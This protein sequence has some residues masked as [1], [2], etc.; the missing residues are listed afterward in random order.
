MHGSNTCVAS[1]RCALPLLV[2]RPQSLTTS[3]STTHLAAQSTPSCGVTTLA[4]THTTVL[5]VKK[6]KFVATAG[7]ITSVEDAVQLLQRCADPCA[8][9]NCYAYQLASGTIA[10]AS[11][12]GEPSGTAGRPIL[13]A[14]QAEG[15]DGVA[16]VVVR[17]VVRLTA[18]YTRPLHNLLLGTMVASNW[19]Q[20]ASPV[21]MG[22]RPAIACG[23]R[24]V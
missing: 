16:V 18:T 12:D 13:S 8:S 23:L 4:D 15:L 7:P 9:H 19:V 14:I 11:D 1:L 5:E 10:K 20:V 3:R 6:S 2:L 17:Y 22:K 24:H 21:R